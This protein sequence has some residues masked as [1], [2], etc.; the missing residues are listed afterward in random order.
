M[1]T[2]KQEEGV[3]TVPELSVGTRF[4]IDGWIDKENFPNEEPVVE[5]EVM[6]SF[7]DETGDVPCHCD[8]HQCAFDCMCGGLID[9][10]CNAADRKDGKNVRY[11]EYIDG[12]EY[13]W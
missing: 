1:I 8:A 12:R 11:V 13:H 3:I 4:R 2:L 5:F 9:C 10:V 7:P 6:E